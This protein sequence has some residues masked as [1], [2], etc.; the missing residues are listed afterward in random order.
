MADLRLSPP[1][2]GALPDAAS[3]PP[4]DLAAGNAADSPGATPDP[5]PGDTHWYDLPDDD[6]AP[7]EE[8]EED[9][10]GTRRRR[11]RRLGLSRL[12]SRR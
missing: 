12:L 10:S 11:P 3:Q 9:G 8:P 1:P 5:F 2:G 4:A 7:E 6:A